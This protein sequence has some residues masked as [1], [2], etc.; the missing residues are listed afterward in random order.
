MIAGDVRD[1]RHAHPL[2]KFI[3]IVVV[4]VRQAQHLVTPA[5]EFTDVVSGGSGRDHRKVYRHLPRSQLAR[6]MH[7]NIVDPGHVAQRIEGSDP[8]S[9]YMQFEDIVFPAAPQETEILATG[10]AFPGLGLLQHIQVKGGYHVPFSALLPQDH[11]QHLK[12]DHGAGAFT[13]SIDLCFRHREQSG[14]HRF[15]GILQPV[16]LIRRIRY[17]PGPLQF[18]KQGKDSCSQIQ[19]IDW[20]LLFGCGRDMEGSIYRAGSGDRGAD[21]RGDLFQIRRLKGRQHRLAGDADPLQEPA[22]GQAVPQLYVIFSACVFIHGRSPVQCL[23][24]S[25]STVPGGLL[26]KS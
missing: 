26:V 25:S 10:Y 19:H 8:G 2:Q 7:G 4:Q 22:V 16:A 1:S 9:D 3:S 15:I 24:Y 20:S 6:H 14:Q 12:Q 21:V 5:P 13:V 11:M 17:L 23:S 18:F